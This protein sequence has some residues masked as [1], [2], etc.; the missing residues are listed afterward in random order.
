MPAPAIPEPAQALLDYIEASPTPWH[1]ARNAAAR[2]EAAGYRRLHERERWQLARGDRAYV[3]RDDSA[4]IALHA[5]TDTAGAGY[6]LI[7]A[8]TDSPGLR[9][10][11]LG[12]HARAGV[13]ALGVEVY[14]SPILATFTDRDLGLAGRVVVREDDA[15]ATRLVRFAQ[16]M[17]RLPNVAIHLERKVNQEGLRFDPN[18]DGNALLEAL[19]ALPPAERLRDLLGTALGVAPDA[20]RDFEL[21]LY[22]AQAGAAF[23]PH[24]Q[25]LASRQLDNLACCHAA[26]SALLAAPGG[27]ATAVVALFDHE[28]VGSTSSRGAASVLLPAVL[29]RTGAALGL[30]AEDRARALAAGFLVSADMAHAVH[31]GRPELH[32][33][34]H[35][36][37]LNGGPVLKV[38]AAQRYTT[39]ASGAARFRAACER[40]EV[41]CQT[42]VHRADL[43][44]GTTVGPALAAALGVQAVDAGSAMWAMHSARESAGAHDPA[45]LERA[46]TA[47]LTD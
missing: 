23:G 8:H 36:P 32:D 24:G 40:A 6:R 46:L 14:G 11:P 12:A 37:H 16:P 28:E 15:L 29:E 17:A 45:Y 3:L 41:P 9:V 43:P 31:P 19:G 20:V 26:I 33:P 7:A 25:Y 30:D 39:D 47:V 38:N 13:L 21:A 44:C 34:Q 1:A 2:L 22:D 4:L 18:R 35:T 5:G 10:R 27:G 42:Y